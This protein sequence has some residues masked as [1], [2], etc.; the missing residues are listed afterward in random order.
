MQLCESFYGPA[1]GRAIYYHGRVDPL[2]VKNGYDGETL[3]VF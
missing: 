1:E 2:V 3:D